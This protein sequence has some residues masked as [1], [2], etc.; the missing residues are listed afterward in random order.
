MADG[1]ARGRCRALRAPCGASGTRYVSM[2]RLYVLQVTQNANPIL[3]SERRM[4]SWWCLCPP[5]K[6][7]KQCP[8]IPGVWGSLPPMPHGDPR[9]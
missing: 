8:A 6:V 4:W 5:P 7:T 3:S 1:G 2:R 9:C